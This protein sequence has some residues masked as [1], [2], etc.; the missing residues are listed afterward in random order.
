MAEAQNNHASQVAAAHDGSVVVQV[1]GNQN[2][3]LVRGRRFLSYLTPA[4][5]KRRLD[6]MDDQAL[7]LLRADEAVTGFLGRDELRDEF[8]AWANTSFP[9]QP[10]SI[11]VVTGAA[12]A[13]P[14]SLLR[15]AL[16]GEP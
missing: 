2:V 16:P 1:Q 5:R 14:A 6:R 8:V 12:G 7:R 3:I 11:R 10:L 15:E 13:N 9:G 4:A